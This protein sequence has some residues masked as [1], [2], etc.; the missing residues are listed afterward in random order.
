[1]IYEIVKADVISL[2]KDDISNNITKSGIMGV[3]IKAKVE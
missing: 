2:S 1:M 3:I